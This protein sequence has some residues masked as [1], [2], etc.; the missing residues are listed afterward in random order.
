LVGLLCKVEEDGARLT[1]LR[2]TEGHCLGDRALF[3]CGAASDRCAGQGHKPFRARGAGG[4]GR[5]VTLVPALATRFAS[6]RKLRSLAGGRAG[7]RAYPCRGAL[8]VVATAARAAR[9]QL[10][11]RRYVVRS[12][13]KGIDRPMRLR[14]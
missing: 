6:G 3:L 2:L 5:G 8:L 13:D 9:D 10:Q 4:A 12:C 1:L 7:R 14:Q 11:A